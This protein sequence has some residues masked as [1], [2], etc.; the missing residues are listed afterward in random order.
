MGLNIKNDETHELAKRLASLTGETMTQAVTV[1]LRDRLAR[2]KAKRNRSRVAE[3]LMEIG[4]RNAARPVLDDR[5]PDE[6]IGYDE[7]GLPR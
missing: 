7:R 4:R 1:A 5:S 6:I 2:E 3:R